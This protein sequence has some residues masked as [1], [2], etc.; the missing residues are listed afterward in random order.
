MVLA[1]YSIQQQGRSVLT[2]LPYNSLCKMANFA[3]FQRRVIFRILSVLWAV[4]C[5]EQL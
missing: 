2:S 4:F 5:I 1:E 3:T